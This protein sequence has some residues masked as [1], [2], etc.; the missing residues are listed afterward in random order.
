MVVSSK[1]GS[2]YTLA[3]RGFMNFLAQLLRF[4]VVGGLNTFIDILAFNLLVW[5]L[6]TRNA[7]LLIVYN[8]LAY[9]IGAVNS[10]CWN[11]LWT[12]KQRSKATRT[13]WAL[14]VMMPFSGWRQPY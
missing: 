11:K 2:Q 3:R 14:S 13:L 5:G 12:F 1:A 6:P 9:L 7:A 4:C 8:S 10:F